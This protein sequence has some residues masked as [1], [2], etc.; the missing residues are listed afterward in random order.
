MVTYKKIFFSLLFLCS[1]YTGHAAKPDYWRSD[2]IKVARLL[3]KA[4]LLDSGSNLMIYFARELRGL[5]YM[6]KTL[7]R[8]KE[9]RLVINLRQMDCTTYVET[10][11]A[12]TM[13]AKKGYTTFDQFVRNLRM[14]RYEDGEV[15][16]PKRMHY[17]THWINENIKKNIVAPIPEPQELF[18]ATQTVKAYYM[19]THAHRYPMM[20]KNKWMTR[21]IRQMEQRITGKQYAYI[22]KSR[23]NDSA[24][25]R[26]TIKDGDI[27]AIL[28]S[29]AGLDTSHIGIAVWHSDGLH[30]L[31]ASSVHQKVVEEPMLLKQYMMRHPSQ[32]GIRVVRPL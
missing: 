6:G 7:E 14:V 24:T 12:L 13:C 23:L 19:T 9:E 5:P 27:I 3:R 11:L 25:L 31:N 22:P 29:R 4:T 16:Y 8:N 15:T 32:I 26:Q 20:A 30:M 10:V 21:E 1:C 28:T 18:T 17:F 2:S